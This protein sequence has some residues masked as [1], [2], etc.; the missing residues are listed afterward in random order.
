[1][2]QYFQDR[3]AISDRVLGG[4][5][6]GVVYLAHEVN[7]Q[8]QVA[9]KIIDLKAAA[10]QLSRPQTTSARMWDD[11]VVQLEN[12]ARQKVLREIRILAQ[13]SHVGPFFPRR[14]LPINISLTLLSLI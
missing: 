9:C 6:Y 5:F 7:T 11:E 8:K 10:Q 4:G 1:M 2:A 14:I 13:L 3:Y 12:A